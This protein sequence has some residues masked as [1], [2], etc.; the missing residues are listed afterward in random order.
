MFGNDLDLGYLSD[1]RSSF[2]SFRR[3]TYVYELEEFLVLFIEQ[4][5]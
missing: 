2:S 5:D 3:Y 1:F 4:R